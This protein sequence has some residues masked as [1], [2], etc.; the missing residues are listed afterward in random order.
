MKFEFNDQARTA[1]RGSPEL[2]IE[3]RPG[4]WV[5]FE[6]NS[7][8]GLLAVTSSKYNK[9][10]KWSGTEWELQVRDGVRV[11]DFCCPGAWGSTWRDIALG[12]LPIREGSM[13]MDERE[14]AARAIAPQL[15][16]KAYLQ[17]AVKSANENESA[18][19]ALATAPEVV[20][21]S[22]HAGLLAW[23]EQH[24]VTGRVITGNATPQDVRGRDVYG[25]LP[26]WLAAEA[27]RVTEV[28]MPGLP[29]EY[30]GKEYSPAEMDAWGAHMVRYQ[31]RVIP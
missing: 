1:G 31:V 6:G 7:I 8:P 12:V 9:C 15:A 23:L 29:L 27:A 14:E 5:R 18:L 26:L 16:E 22:R 10:G 30:R 24:G 28:S 2:F 13:N 25:I 21:V 11:V 19:A 3:S 20:I 4:E 17:E